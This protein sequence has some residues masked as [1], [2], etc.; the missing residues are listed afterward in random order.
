M[1]RHDTTMTP[2][3]LR[4]LLRDAIPAQSSVEYDAPPPPHQFFVPKSHA[5]ALHLNI[6][7]VLGDRGMGKTFWWSALQSEDLRRY[8][9]AVE[10]DTRIKRTTLVRAG[11][12][13]PLDVDRYPSRMVLASLLRQG[14]EPYL[15]WKAVMVWAVVSAS[16]L[17][18]LPKWEDRVAWVGTNAEQAERLVQAR[19]Q[20]LYKSEQDQLV[21]FDSLDSATADWDVLFHLVSGL[22][23]VALE[24]RGT[25][26]IRVKVFLRT[27]QFDERRVAR[28]PDASKLAS[29]SVRLS[30]LESELF[31]LLWQL[32][33]FHPEKG[34][35]FQAHLRGILEDV[36]GRSAAAQSAQDW[37]LPSAAYF[38]T[39][40]QQAIFHA[41]TGPLMG[42]NARRGFPY[43]WLPNH[44]ADAQGEIS[45]RSFLIAL[46]SAAQ[47]T[48]EQQ[49]GW[50]YALHPHGLHA[51]LQ[52][53]SAVR[54]DEIGET[55]WVPEVM[56]DLE[57][58]TVPFSL[59]SLETL[60]ASKG[61]LARVRDYGMSD[62]NAENE[63]WFV[64]AHLDDGPAGVCRDLE[65]L[66]V[67]RTMRTGKIDVP[68]I[69]RLGFGLRRRGGVP[70]RERRT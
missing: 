61:T 64:P 69:Y 40:A 7:L 3:A 52:D 27:D 1:S 28:F 20:V 62:D 48:A 22:L 39:E 51:G 14:V 66:G 70:P 19:D 26:R 2:M 16:D 25:R 55:R 65:S 45:P 29:S 53:A 11:F 60:W 6:P 41:I 38:D 46:R 10:P 44:L 4:E 12:G 54:V 23:Q 37:L 8:M 35:A 32:L 43:S 47:Y 63:P 15:L 49:A 9:Q 36:A 59:D 58:E 50:G 42:D 31:G 56:G 24:F 67:L 21:V 13:R 33:A 5:R 30:W 18:A 68:D 34:A 57:G 17:P